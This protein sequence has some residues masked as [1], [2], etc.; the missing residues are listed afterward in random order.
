MPAGMPLI[1]AH[2]HLFAPAQRAERDAI[3]AREP[4]FAEMYA[5]PAAKLATA[6][7]AAQSLPPM[8]I[9]VT[10]SLRLRNGMPSICSASGGAAST[11]TSRPA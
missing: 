2:T 7:A 6:Q 10:P 4:A 8:T 11:Q 5:D 9:G 1:D 3:A